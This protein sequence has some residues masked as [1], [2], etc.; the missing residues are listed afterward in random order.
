MMKTAIQFGAG[1]IGRGFIGAL[2]AQAG[3]E[4]VF[5]DVN[6]AVIDKLNQDHSYTVH[7]MD[8]QCYDQKITNVRGVDSTTPAVIDEL[9]AASIVT[10]AVGPM[11][12]PRIAPTIAKAIMQRAARGAEP[13]QIIACENALRATS[14]LKEAVYEALD[15]AGREYADRMVGFADCAVDRIVPPVRTENPIDVVVEEYFEWD[16]ERSG[17]IGEPPAIPGMTLVD[18][19]MAYIERK[20]FTLNTGHAITAYLGCLRGYSTI[21]EAIAVPEIREIV[22]S[23]M[24]ESGEGLIRKYGFDEQKHAAYV[25]KILARFG[26]PYLQDDVTRVG[27]EP[28]RKLSAS[29]RLVKPMLTAHGYDLPVAHL[30]VGIA[31][32]LCYNNPADAQSA[33]LQET[34]QEKGVMAALPGLTGIEEPAMLSRIAQVYETLAKHGTEPDFRLH[35]L[36]E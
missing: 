25:R 34:L 24:K 32:A 17:F 35:T 15:Q 3:Y 21:A 7:V 11:I 9:V 14:Q 1:N 12:L 22:S 26:N 8:T 27:R 36:A 18:D 30:I 31:A 28:L 5:A 33:S 29:D 6:A 20:L 4:V 13:L 16:V 19:L 23:A 10:T 2:L